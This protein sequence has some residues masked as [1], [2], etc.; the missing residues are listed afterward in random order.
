MDKQNYKE[1]MHGE[2]SS[3]Q[4]ENI[5]YVLQRTEDKI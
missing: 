3:C 5:T 4:E 2:I 1:F